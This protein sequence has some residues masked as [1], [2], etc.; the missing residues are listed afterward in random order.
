MSNENKT[1]V[2]LYFPRETLKRI[3]ERRGRYYS[4]NMYFL[5]IAEEHLANQDNELTKNGEGLAASIPAAQAPPTVPTTTIPISQPDD[6]ASTTT[7][8]DVMSTTGGIS[9][10]QPLG[11]GDDAVV[12]K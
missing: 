3:D 10:V 8:A 12:A 7:Q 11:S 2:G 4:R 6:G 1:H 9:R 5:K